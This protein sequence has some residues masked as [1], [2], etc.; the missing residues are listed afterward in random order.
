MNTFLSA[1]L[2]LTALT[3]TPKISV[4]PT[5]SASVTGCWNGYFQFDATKSYW[6]GS[7]LCKAVT[8]ADV[9]TSCPSGTKEVL[10]R[11][12]PSLAGGQIPTD[13]M[14]V[15]RWA[16]RVPTDLD[17]TISLG[18][19]RLSSTDVRVPIGGGT[20]RG[21]SSD[22]QYEYSYSSAQPVNPGTPTNPGTSA[23][24]SLADIYSLQVFEFRRFYPYQKLC[25]STAKLNLN[26]PLKVKTGSSTNYLRSTG[27]QP[28]LKQE[29]DPSPVTT[30]NSWSRITSIPSADMPK[31][32]GVI[33]DTSI[34]SV[35]KKS[36]NNNGTLKIHAKKSSVFGI[37]ASY[38]VFSFDTKITEDKDVEINFTNTSTKWNRLIC[39]STKSYGKL[40]ELPGTGAA[41]GVTGIPPFGMLISISNDG[42]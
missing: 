3:S 24:T 12:D 36:N 35:P 17:F 29:Y 28:I 42:K 7:A 40:S 10:Y 25:I 32:S 11:V 33:D 19:S 27:L 37:S 16:M 13:R 5:T 1:L 2:I 6:N 4:I 14:E 21:L 38:L 15:L 31:C 22:R 26:V 39:A 23:S 20:G 9:V 41:S 34:F 18:Q 30:L 8:T